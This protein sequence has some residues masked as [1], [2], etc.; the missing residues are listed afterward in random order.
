MKN[1]PFP[2]DEITDKSASPDQIVY[3]YKVTPQEA[4]DMDQGAGKLDLSK[5]TFDITENP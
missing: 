2:Y 3:T 1:L 5:G 4:P